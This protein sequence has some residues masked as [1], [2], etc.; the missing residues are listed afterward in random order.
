MHHEGGAQRGE[1]LEE[2]RG[3]KCLVS[4]PFGFLLLLRALSL[5]G[6]CS[7]LRG[8]CLP[9]VGVFSYFLF[10]EKYTQASFGEGRHFVFTGKDENRPKEL[11]PFFDRACH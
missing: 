8:E 3:A 2:D 9:C 7:V 10:F 11:N 6:L 4:T 1:G 5:T